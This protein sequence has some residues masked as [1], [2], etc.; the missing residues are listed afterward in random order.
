MSRIQSTW[1]NSNKGALIVRLRKKVTFAVY[2]EM[3]NL[4][5]IAQMVDNLVSHVVRFKSQQIT[6]YIWL[7]FAPPKFLLT[8]KLLL[9]WE[10]YRKA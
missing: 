6:W 2:A 1:Q 4:N 3:D 8:Q 10:R 7:R 5:R 9:C